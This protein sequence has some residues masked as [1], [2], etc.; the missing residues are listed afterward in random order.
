MRRTRNPSDEGGLVDSDLPRLPTSEGAPTEPRSPN[1]L[2]RAPQNAAIGLVYAYAGQRQGWRLTTIGGTGSGKTY[3]QRRLVSRAHER[4]DYVLI[5]DAKDRTP[6]YGG[7]IRS[8]VADVHRDPP[9]HKTVVIRDDDPETVAELGWRI[10]DKGGTALVVIDELYDALSAPMHFRARGASRISEIYRKGR[11]RGV[12][13]LGSTQIPQSLPTVVIDLSDFKFI[14]RLDS[15]SLNYI[16]ASL[17]LTHEI[18]ST[19][20][21]LAIGQFVVVQQ[22]V[23]WNRTVYGPD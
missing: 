21:S 12:S 22:G 10:A 11:S 19:I 17:N 4:H 3:L 15:R 1:G 13:I 18:V 20:R 14:F 16:E 2:S 8:M 9:S 5:H 6:Q 7:A 23:E